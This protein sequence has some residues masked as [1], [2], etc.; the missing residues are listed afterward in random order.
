MWLLLMDA[1]AVGVI[2]A[3]ALTLAVS[4]VVLL[5]TLVSLWSWQPAVGVEVVKRG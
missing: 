3:S 1:V 4:S 5:P 2:L